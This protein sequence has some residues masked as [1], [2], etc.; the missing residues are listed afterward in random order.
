MS[1]QQKTIGL[2]LVIADKETKEEEVK[3]VDVV[4]LYPASETR[5]IFLLETERFDMENLRK[6][7]GLPFSKEEKEAVVCYL[8]RH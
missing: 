2:G 3:V 7:A 6:G 4:R 8:L 1:L 5:P